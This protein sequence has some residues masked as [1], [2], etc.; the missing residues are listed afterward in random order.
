MVMTMHGLP[1]LLCS[2]FNIEG[3]ILNFRISYVSLW[4]SLKQDFLNQMVMN[5]CLRRFLPI[6]FV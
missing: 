6:L 2:T 1:A 5:F 4:N 3:Y